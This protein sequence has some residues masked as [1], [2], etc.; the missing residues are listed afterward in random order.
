MRLPRAAPLPPVAGL[1]PPDARG[2]LHGSGK[3]TNGLLTP[4]T[5]EPERL[6]P[7][8]MPTRGSLSVPIGI[9]IAGIV[10]AFI[11]YFL[12]AE[13]WVLPSPP[14]PGPRLASVNSAPIL[15]PAVTAAPQQ[16]PRPMRAQGDDP[17]TSTDRDPSSQQAKAAPAANVVT[18]DAAAMLQPSEPAPKA[19]PPRK[20]TRTLNSEEIELLVKQGEQFIAAGDLVTA[21]IV[22]Q[23]AADGGDAAAAMMLGATYD[24]IVLAKLGVVGITADVE[25]ARGWYQ[26]ADGLGSTGAARRLAVLDKP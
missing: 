2:H 1:A 19:P 13:G 6:G 9:S 4:R 5:L 11:G 25:Q 23:R 18:G 20:V 22:F 24:P 21:R 3:L 8:P 12:A 15:T 7:P 14:A 26:K 16:Q 17:V 10:V